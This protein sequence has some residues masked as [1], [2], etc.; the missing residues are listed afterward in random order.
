MKVGDL[1]RIKGANVIGLV[2][3]PLPDGVGRLDNWDKKRFVVYSTDNKR[4]E[5]SASKYV[6]VISESR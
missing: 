4:Y 2:V 1:V 6:E 5:L 3:A